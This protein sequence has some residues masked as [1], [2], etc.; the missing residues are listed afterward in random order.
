LE[1]FSTALNVDL[2]D[3]L[4]AGPVSSDPVK[5]HLAMVSFGILAWEWLTKVSGVEPVMVAGHSLGE[6]TAL[7]CAGVVDPLT[8]LRLAQQRGIL[9]AEACNEFPGAMKAFVGAPLAEMRALF[10]QCTGGLVDP[11]QVWE[12]NYNGPE[13]LVVAGELSAINALEEAFKAQ[14]IPA[15]TLATAGAFHTPFMNVAA[16]KLAVYA[17]NITFKPARIPLV[18]SL[19]GRQLTSCQG[20]GVH[21]AL[22]LV[23]PVQWLA[24]MQ[25]M[26]RAQI[27]T[28][29]EAG[30]DCGVLSQLAASCKDWSVATTRVSKLFEASPVTVA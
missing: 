22:Q 3:L 17:E 5:V 2:H 21:L 13:Q 30:P 29:I 8:A 20:L 25:F 23:S 4:C 18:S 24:A 26:Q 6:I 1:E 15:V 16:R 27:T 14:G 28:L 12:A 11:M 7:A 19:T 10:C 9:I